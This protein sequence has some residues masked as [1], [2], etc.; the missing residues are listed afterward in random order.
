MH[1]EMLEQEEAG[2]DRRQMLYVDFEDERLADFQAR[3]LGL[4]LDVQAALYPDVL[5][6]PRMLFLDEIQVVPGW[7]P[8]VRRAVERE[9]IRVF[10]SGSSS[11]MLST[12]V[13]TSL[14]GRGMAV[15]ISPFSFREFLRSDG[16]IPSA[17][18]AARERALL[19]NRFAH[20]LPA[21]GFPETVAMDEKMR[22]ATLQEY[23][24]VLIHRD[25]VERHGLSNVEAVRWVVRHLL[26]NGTAPFSVN[27]LYSTLKSQ[28]R[29]AGKDLL[30][31][32]IEHLQDAFA[33]F[34]LEL[35]SPSR[36][37]RAANPRKAY[38][39]DPGLL[40]AFNWRFS[41]NTGSLLENAVFC[42][43]RRRF[44]RICYYRTKAG[45]E[46]DFCAVDPSGRPSLFQVSA[47]ISTPA[48]RIRELG[49]LHEA[50]AE[51]DL[52]RGTLIT[53]DEEGEDTVD[54]RTVH[55][56]AAWRWF[57]QPLEK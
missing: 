30:Y 43:L 14:R 29:P 39:A 6:N 38:A 47:D 42:E 1:Q 46:V 25:I 41:R 21:G 49:A 44:D 50:M 24:N 15:E 56:E 20:Y 51:L 52:L 10:V 18:P 40:T 12:E 27:R 34:S 9:G 2:V 37:V 16:L 3:D 11:R 8:F 36:N 32:L 31:A 23:V 4:L 7:E 53:L 22:I 28:G 33:V 48:T 57:A 19:R 5:D 55:L 13:H 54:G 26:E 17:H 45:K 35:C